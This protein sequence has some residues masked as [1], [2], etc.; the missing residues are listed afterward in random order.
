MSAITLEQAMQRLEEDIRKFETW[1]REKERYQ[2]VEVV[3]GGF[4]YALKPEAQGSDPP[5]HICAY[6][7]EHRRRS[8]LTSVYISIGRAEMLRCQPCGAEIF[9]HGVDHRPDSAAGRK[10]FRPLA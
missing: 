3:T 6:C 1:E 9:T 4:A 2:L 5:H 10:G 8:I 7:Y